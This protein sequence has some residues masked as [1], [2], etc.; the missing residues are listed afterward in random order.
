MINYLIL[1]I[2][3]SYYTPLFAGRIIKYRPRTFKKGIINQVFS[4]VKCFTFWVMFI[5]LNLTFFDY[6]I[7]NLFYSLALAY[8]VEEYYQ[9]NYLDI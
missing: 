8:Y 9:K 4:C 5:L 1:L 7:W 2:L 3:F 6:L